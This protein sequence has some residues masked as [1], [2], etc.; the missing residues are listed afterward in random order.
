[1]RSDLKRSERFLFRRIVQPAFLGAILALLFISSLSAQTTGSIAGTVQ[2]SSGAVLADAKITLTSPAL[3]VAQTTLTTGQGTYRFPVLP[4]GTYVL[5]V[6]APGFQLGKRENIVIVAGFSATVDMPMAL[7]GQA[8]TVAVTA[9]APALDTESTKIQDTFEASTL[10]ELPTA[11]DMWSLIGVAPGLKLS[12]FDVGGSQTGTQIGYSSYGMSGQ[13]RVNMDGVNMTEGNSAT[14]AYTDYSAFEEVQMGTSGNDASASSPG[15]QINFVVKSGGNQFHGEFYQ[16]YESSNFQGTNIST[17]QLDRGAGTGTR[18]TSYHDTNG[19][20]GGPI[21]KDKLWFFASVRS[22]YIGTTITGYPVND[23]GSLPFYTRLSNATYKLTYQ[24]NSKNKISQMTNFERKQQPYRN[25]SNTQYGDA[26]YDQDLVEWIGD[27]EWNST[28]SANANFNLRVGSWGYNW[29][30]SAYKGADGVYDYRQVDSTSGDT[31]GAFD[32]QRYNRRRFQVEPTFSYAASHFLKLNHFFT[33]GFLTEKETYNFQQ[34]SF[35]GGIQENY[36]SAVGAPDFTT[37]NSITLYNTPAV[38]TDYL[39][40]NGAYAQDKI[41][42]NKHLTLNLG[43]RWDYNN[44][45]RPNETVRP[46]LQFASFFYQG[47]ALPNGYSI[48]AT[49]PTLQIPGAQGILN[50]PHA[51]TGRIGG[52]YDL[53]GDGKTSIKASYG[54]FYENPGAA[55][56]NLVNPLRVLSDTFK[57]IN[58]TN[59]PFNISQLGA[60]QSSTG[61]ALDPIDPKIR[62]PFMDDFNGFVEHQIGNGFVVR[63]GFVYR[64]LRHDWALQELNRTANLFTKIGTFTDP[65]PT[66]TTPTQITTYDIPV[67]AGSPLPASLQEIVT[68]DKNNSFWRSIEFTAIKRLTNKWSM[69]ATFLGTWSNTPNDFTV[70]STALTAASPGGGTGLIP[71]YPTLS[72]YNEARVYNSNFRIYGTY[73]AKWGIV[74]SPIYR[75]QLGTPYAREVTVTGLNI[76]TIVLPVDPVGTYRTQNISIFD[77]RV[78]KR[79]KIKERYEVGV[80]FDAFNINNSNADITQDPITGTK[81]TV[82]NGVKLSY[83]RFDAPTSVVSPRIF[84]LGAKFSF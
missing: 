84:R 32:P 70:G 8:Q 49:F 71:Y 35:I 37:P 68:P 67:T 42:V 60:F 45:W 48:P 9:E 22:Q 6:E 25:A 24:I 10:R 12:N 18:I 50:Y 4:P 21:L 39:R 29:N 34:Y 63:G 79:F 38:A 11:R 59:A 74:I 82:V 64:V 3:V 44:N 41:K 62:Q 78:E 47:A 26:V 69:T 83:Q 16:D 80:F 30:N 19:D 2:D 1:M 17:S 58:P 52:A 15:V 53:F 7:A 23:P 27:L 56:S 40:H 20:F 43:I 81:S 46:D 54:R 36:T 31:A 13:Q 33:F 75:F 65:G 73:N 51:F 5:T 76:G 77:T 55:I 57:W 72:Q 61:G 66:G 28:I 14:S